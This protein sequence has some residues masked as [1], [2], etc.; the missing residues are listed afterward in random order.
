MTIGH[1]VKIDS[2]ST[3][4]PGTG[5]SGGCCIGKKVLIGGHSFIVPHKKVGD[6]ATIAAGSVVFRNV[7]EG[8]TVLGNPAKRMEILEKDNGVL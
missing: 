3:V 7:M 2:Y 8:T 4:M 5:I 6:G 1:D